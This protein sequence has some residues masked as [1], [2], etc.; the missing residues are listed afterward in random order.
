MRFFVVCFLIVCFS[1]SNVFSE[2]GLTAPKSVDV[3]RMRVNQ[4]GRFEFA[5]KNTS[6][7]EI[8]I[9]GIKTSCSCTN[10]KLD[11]DQTMPAGAER[12]LTGEA[13]FGGTPGNYETKVG[14]AFRGKSDHANESVVPIRG[15][16]IAD[17]VL[18]KPIIDFGPVD[19][20][21]GFQMATLTAKRGNSGE[22]WDSIRPVSTNEHVEVTMETL[23]EAQSRFTVRF[24]PSGLPMSMFHCTVKF[25]MLRKAEPLPHEI[26]VP[27]TARVK[28]PLKATPPSIYLGSV[29][30]GDAINKEVMVFSSELDLRELTV[31]TQPENGLAKINTTESGTAKIKLRIVPRG[32]AQPFSDTL[33]I[34]HKPSRTKLMI[35]VL[36]FV[37]SADTE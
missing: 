12:V 3:G 22:E 19:M 34:V 21:A 8:E 30:S 23:S 37:K 24:N 28:G 25:Q 26:E 4:T 5:V 10:V 16:V 32:T 27:V 2:T 1:G 31:E 35:P 15:K 7:E 14:I 13:S 6:G 20:N 33:I 18:D 29:V 11:G 9:T 36:G 17:L